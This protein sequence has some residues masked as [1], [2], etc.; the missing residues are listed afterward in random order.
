MPTPLWNHSEIL[1][2]LNHR[3]AFQVDLRE[4]KVKLHSSTR[5]SG[6]NL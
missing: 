1:D 2:N 5:L 4:V 3:I 6:A